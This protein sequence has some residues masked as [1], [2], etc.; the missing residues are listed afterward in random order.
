[1]FCNPISTLSPLEAVDLEDFLAMQGGCVLDFSRPR[2]FEFVQRA[3]GV[4]LKS[5]RY[6]VDGDGMARRLRVFWRI[7][8]DAMTATLLDSLIQYASR[9]DTQWDERRRRLAARAR[10]TVDRLRAGSESLEQLMASLDPRNDVQ[11]R[12]AIERMRSSIET[13][14][15][16]AIGSAKELIEACCK[17]VL[18]ENFEEVK[19]SINMSELTKRALQCVSLIPKT[20]HRPERAAEHVTEL[21]TALSALVLSVTRLR[22]HYGTGHGREAGEQPLSPRHAQLAVDA[23]TTFAVFLLDRR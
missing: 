22:N 5:D 14:P 23:A 3:C 15:S 19:D 9:D 11:L 13:D 12:L 2:L 10:V 17:T 21:V 4:D 18:L 7:E 6:A 16:L 8:S 1:M 20:V